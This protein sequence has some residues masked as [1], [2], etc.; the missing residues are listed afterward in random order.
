MRNMKERIWL[1]WF[2]YLAFHYP[3][4]F[5]AAKAVISFRLSSDGRLMSVDVV[6]SE[7]GDVFSAFCVEAIQRAAPFGNLPDEVMDLTG[8]DELDVQFGF[9]FW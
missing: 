7:G 2:P 8:K 4:D 5:R 9:N 1:A 6:E 3:K